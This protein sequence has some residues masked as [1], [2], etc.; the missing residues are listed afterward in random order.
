MKGRGALQSRG[1]CWLYTA[2][3]QLMLSWNMFK[4]LFSHMTR[5]YASMTAAEKAFFDSSIEAPCPHG[6]NF[7]KIYFYKFL[8]QFCN[9]TTAPPE[10]TRKA[11]KS[12]NLLNL[13]SPHQGYNRAP[14]RPNQPNAPAV[15]GLWGGH[16]TPEY[17]K[18]IKTLGITEFSHAGVTAFPNGFAKRAREVFTDKMVEFV[19]CHYNTNLGSVYHVFDNKIELSRDWFHEYPIE[20]KISDG[21]NQ[22][23]IFDLACAAI[24]VQNLQSGALHASHSI[25]AFRDKDG[26][27]YLYDSNDK[28]TSRAGKWWDPYELDRMIR[29]YVAPRYPQFKNGRITNIFYQNF[30][31]VSR[32]AAAKIIPMARDLS[33]NI[34]F[35]TSS[36]LEKYP[37]SKVGLLL[38]L[39]SKVNAGTLSEAQKAKIIKNY[40]LNPVKNFNTSKYLNRNSLNNLTGSLNRKPT[41]TNLQR[42]KIIRN[43]K[44]YKNFNPTSLLN[45]PN[46]VLNSQVKS[47][48][49]TKAQRQ[50]ILDARKARPLLNFETAKQYGLHKNSIKEWE[51]A[52]YR[53]TESTKRKIR[54]YLAKP[55]P[56]V[57]NLTGSP[58]PHRQTTT[59]RRPQTAPRRQTTTPRQSPRRRLFTSPVRMRSLPPSPIPF[60]LNKARGEVNK[61]KTITERRA[62]LRLRAVD[63]E[64]NNWGALGNYIKMKNRSQRIATEN[65]R[66][67]RAPLSPGAG[68]NV[69]KILHALG[70]FKTMKNRQAYA[71]KKKS[72]LKANG[73]AT[74][75]NLK[76]I[77]KRVKELDN[78]QRQAKQL[79]KKP[80]N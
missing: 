47:G 71:V 62:Y 54:N 66:A 11:Q 26:Q 9:L 48:L 50:K 13:W 43:Y 22:P 75:A 56:E 49:L 4:I 39:N 69:N 29:E 2:I 28:A 34:N 57:I 60:S 68:L 70:T 79:K 23:R 73:I 35:N 10:L 45:T 31:Y 19:V 15:P 1:T 32:I 41:L 67:A 6:N 42:A 37:N 5:E 55:P 59:P 72:E 58:T 76:K 24:G 78:L 36:Y 12:V 33:R 40:N 18:A 44:N 8:D 74:P 17:I 20:I 14:P 63:M 61:L 25:V 30:T 77:T 46:N 16:T 27:G 51:E 64:T 21:K 38:S 7:K 3:N 53:L 80:N 52:S 65:T